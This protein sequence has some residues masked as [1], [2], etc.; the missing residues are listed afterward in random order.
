[1]AADVSSRPSGPAIRAIDPWLSGKFSA[2]K[3]RQLLS[4]EE[5]ARLATIA[6]IVRFKKG[7][8]IYS[9]GK[10]AKAI[11]NIVSGI[12]KTYKPSANGD[13]H[14]A[15]FLYPQDLFGLT[16][17]GRYTNSAMAITPVTAYA[18]PVPA[19]RRRL[20]KD[21]ALDFHL[22]AKLCHGLREAQRHALLLAQRHASSKLAMFLQLQEH[23]Q[24]ANGK[25]PEIYLSMDRSDIADYV[26]MSLAAVSR[27]FRD[28]AARG[29]IKIRD[30]RHVKIIDRKAFDKLAGD[31]SRPARTR[32]K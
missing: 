32:S 1:M 6:S 19:L 28:L 27:G 17:E 21:A 20:S 10:P 29:V 12:V 14:I 2:G 15:A 22:I 3:S 13:E 16:E 23:V 8:K 26:G 18:L 4:D 7:E 5:S 24:S 31:T 11:F 9:D 25:L 30:R